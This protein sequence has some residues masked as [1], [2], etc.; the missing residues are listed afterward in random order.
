MTKRILL[1]V[2]GPLGD[3][4]HW[5]INTQVAVSWAHAAAELDPRVYPYVPHCHGPRFEAHAPKTRDYEWWLAH[6]LLMVERCDALLRIVGPSAGAD[7]EVA[8]ARELS[9][10][11]FRELWDLE[12]W[13]KL[14]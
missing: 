3:S 5:G 2:A 8:R 13:L 6:C 7:R 11:I 1:Y 10:P 9:L 12:Q 4:D 14:V